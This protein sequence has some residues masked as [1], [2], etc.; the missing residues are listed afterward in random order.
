M[1]GA[2]NVDV[3]DVDRAG[4]VVY[5]GKAHLLVRTRE[6][7]GNPERSAGPRID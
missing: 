1:Q 7:Q 3:P 2:V 4:G 5:G 6:L